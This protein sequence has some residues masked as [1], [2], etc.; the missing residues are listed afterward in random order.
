MSDSDFVKGFGL[1]A[2][3]VIIGNLLFWG[4][5]IWFALWAL[6]QFGVI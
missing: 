2:L 4:G 5:V 3:F 1:L 6:Q